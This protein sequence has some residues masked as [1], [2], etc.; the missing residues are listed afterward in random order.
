MD[1][2]TEPCAYEVLDRKD[3]ACLNCDGFNDYCFHF[4]SVQHLRDFYDNFG[5]DGTDLFR[6]FLKHESEG[7]KN[8][9]RKL[10]RP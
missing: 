4:V 5:S 1:H 2:R 7:G 10:R 6:Q 8:E 9:S 3:E